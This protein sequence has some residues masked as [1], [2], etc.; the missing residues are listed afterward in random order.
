MELKFTSGQMELR[1]QARVFAE[2]ELADGTRYRDEHGRSS[3]RAI[4]KLAEAGFLG[5][6]T[7]RELGGQG[8]DLRGLTEVIREISR[9]DAGT[10]L[11]VISHSLL[12]QTALVRWGS[13]Q[14]KNEY[15]PSLARGELLASCALQ[16]YRYGGSDIQNVAATANRNGESYQLNGSKAWIS[17]GEF[18]HLYFVFARSGNNTSSDDVSVYM[19]ERDRG[20]LTTSLQTDL[21]GLRSAGLSTIEL[22]GCVIPLDH[23]LGDEG[24][25]G[26]IAAQLETF[27]NIGLAA[28][29]LGITE[30]ALE[31][32]VSYA[33]QRRQFNRTIAEFEVIQDKL[34]EI[35]TSFEAA[36]SL[37]NRAAAS[38]D[39]GNTVPALASMAKLFATTTAMKAAN[40]A[41]QIHGGYGYLRENEIERLMRDAK[42][43]EIYGGSAETQRAFIARELLSR[44]HFIN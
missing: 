31:K 41:V 33:K 19:V 5:L 18:V 44:E 29:A 30:A 42:V 40:E 27:K 6:T 23:R 35:G 36:R 20:G 14:Q 10:A 12:C 11:I 1:E 16:E 28:Q 26:Q 7:S 2:N 8:H 32:S 15:L 34:A 3:E 43:S 21:L 22:E 37:T 24:V 17:H 9:V 39:A 38:V 13:I 25:G 4:Q